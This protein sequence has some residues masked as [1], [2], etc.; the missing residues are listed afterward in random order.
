[1]A[2]WVRKRKC[3]VIKAPMK[4]QMEPMKTEEKLRYRKLP[5]T[6]KYVTGL[7]LKSG[8]PISESIKNYFIV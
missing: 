3:L 7:V 4:P 5:T 2:E 1:M 6:F 8:S